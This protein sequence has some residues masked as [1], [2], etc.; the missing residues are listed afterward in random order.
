MSAMPILHRLYFKTP[1]PPNVTKFGFKARLRTFSQIEAFLEH[2]EG[3]EG[4][5]WAI[6]VRKYMGDFGKRVCGRT[7]GCT[8][9]QKYQI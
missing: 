8:L 1:K 4:R 2:F 9:R 6:F 7:G 5:S 3:G